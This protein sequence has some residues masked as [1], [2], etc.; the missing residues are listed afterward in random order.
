MILKIFFAALRNLRLDRCEYSLFLRQG[1]CKQLDRLEKLNPAQP[2]SAREVH[3]C[4]SGEHLLYFKSISDY[5]ATLTQTR[6]FRI[7]KTSARTRPWWMKMNPT[8]QL[9]SQCHRRRFQR[10]APR[11]ISEND[12]LPCRQIWT[13]IAPNHPELP[14]ATRFELFYRVFFCLVTLNKE[15][16]MLSSRVSMASLWSCAFSGT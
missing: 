2:E 11:R 14:T 12:R 13:T 10:R 15:K 9:R 3:P 1:R 6:S 5:G 8:T 4:T 7:S 16:I